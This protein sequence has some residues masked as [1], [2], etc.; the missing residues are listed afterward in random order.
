MS[1]TTNTRLENDGSEISQKNEEDT[2]DKSVFENGKVC[3]VQISDGL[4]NTSQVS[5]QHCEIQK[6]R[7][8]SLSG[9]DNVGYKNM[10]HRRL[11][12]HGD[13]LKVPLVQKDLILDGKLIKS[14]FTK[15]TF[16]VSKENNSGHIQDELHDLLEQNP[17][18]SPCRV[19]PI[20]SRKSPT[21]KPQIKYSQGLPMAIAI[22]SRSH[23]ASDFYPTGSDLTTPNWPK[24]SQSISNDKSPNRVREMSP[25][26]VTSTLQQRFID[27]RK[28]VESK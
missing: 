16:C 19:K 18:R 1:F 22:Q 9:R 21:N 25:T 17:K 26:K 27:D 12:S 11:G 3:E 20:F 6:R 14:N 10:T 5:D 23:E 7:R 15:N 13:I 28:F 8:F 4:K 2:I 24:V